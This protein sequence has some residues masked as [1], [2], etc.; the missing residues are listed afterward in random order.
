M[1]FLV[2]SLVLLAS[3]LAAC[4]STPYP[5][6]SPYYQIPP[7]SRLILDRPIEI[8][9]DSATTRLQFGKILGRSGVNEFEPMCVFEITTVAER[10]QR[11]EP[12]SFEITKVRRSESTHWAAAPS[13][14]G[15]LKASWGWGGG[16]TRYYLKTEMFLHSAVQPQVLAMTCQRAWDSGSSVQT[17]R[18][19]TIAEMQQALG[20]VFRFQLASAPAEGR[21]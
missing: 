15:L 18:P 19:L 13:V 2:P 20:D 14:P 3:I 21:D 9:P 11:V 10:V 8:A 17:Q 1:R 4:Q 12:D 7:G 6:T 16:M 5:V